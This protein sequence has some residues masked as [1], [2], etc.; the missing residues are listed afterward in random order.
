[1]IEL[2]AGGVDEQEARAERAAHVRERVHRAQ[3]EPRVELL[4]APEMLHL[5]RRLRALRRA[6]CG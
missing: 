2:V 4:E 6:A 5:A 3:V 1:M